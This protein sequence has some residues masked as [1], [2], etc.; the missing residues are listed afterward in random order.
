[1]KPV[2]GLPRLAFLVLGWMFV[3][4]GAIGAV[5]P[6]LPTTPF[7]LLAAVCFAR[8]S[9]RFYDWLLRSRLFG[10]L[11]RNWRETGSI[12]RRPK[13]VAI[14][15]IATVGG[16]SIIF[17]L[18]SPWA[19]LALAATLLALIVWLLRVPT[20]ESLGAPGSPSHR[21]AR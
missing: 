10:P 14:F 18:A 19:R 20:T 4:L 21:H 17:F 13:A 12:P 1:L 2:S 7:L 11:I 15:L 16:S 5:L 3:G 6:V 8:S 9:P